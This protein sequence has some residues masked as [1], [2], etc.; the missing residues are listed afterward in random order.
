LA[1]K[2]TLI[3][4]LVSLFEGLLLERNYL[5]IQPERRVALS[6][7]PNQ[8]LYQAEPRPDDLQFSISEWKRAKT[9][10]NAAP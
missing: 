1:Y 5:K 6:L 9:A 8:A 4:P 7:V 10:A 2:K 3:E